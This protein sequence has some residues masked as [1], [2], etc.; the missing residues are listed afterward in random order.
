MYMQVPVQVPASVSLYM[1]AGLAT[2]KLA[3]P[4]ITVHLYMHTS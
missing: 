3:K 4:C 1:A 2:E